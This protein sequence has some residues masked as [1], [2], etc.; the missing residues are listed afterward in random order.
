M[1][2]RQKGWVIA[3]VLVAVPAMLVMF[4]VAALAQIVT[5]QVTDT[6]YR[7]DGTPAGGTVLISWPA[8][9]TSAGQSIASGN[10]SATLTASG[11][12]TV[13]LIP[14]A[15]ANPVGTYY[16]VVYHLD[17]GSVNR[18]YWVVPAS[19]FPVH[20]S[21]LRN[22]VVPTSV[23]MQTVSKSYVDTA[24]AS[25]VA[26]HP[27]DSSNPYVLKAGDTMTG[28]LSLPG[29]PTTPSQATTKNYVDTNVTQ[30]ASGLAQKVSVLPQTDQ[31][32]AQPTGTQLAT[33]RMNGVEYASQYQNSRGNNGIAN[34]VASPDCAGGCEIKAEQTYGPTENYTASQWNNGT[35]VEDHR[36][37]QRHDLYLN[38]DSP[39][40]PGLEAGQVI[41][42]TGTRPTSS[43]FQATHTQTPGS[44]GLLI[45]HQGVAGGSNQFPENI[46]ATVPYFKMGYSALQLKGTYNAQGQH[47]LAPMSSSCFGVGDCLIGSQL[48]LGSG[49]FRDNAD[50]GTHPFDLQILEDSRVFTGVCA[51]GCAPGST[52][53]AITATANSQTQGEGRYLIDTNPAKVLNTGSLIGAGTTTGPNPSAAFSGTNFPISTFFQ[54]AQAAVSQSNDLAP[55]TVTLPIAT[56]GLPTGFASNTAAAPAA[57]G[58]ACVTDTAAADFNIEKFET[59]NYSI[60]D[61]THL[62]LTLTRAHTANATVAIGGLCGYGLEQTVDTASGIRQVFPV[63][64]SYS[65]TG[66][67]YAGG[68]S[69]IVGQIGTTSA[70]ASFSLPITSVTR[71]GNTVTLVTSGNFP[72]DVNGLTL[73]VSGVSD[74]SYNGSFVVTTTSPNRLTYTQTGSNSTSSGG[75]LTL[76]TGGYA[77]YPMAEVTSVMN[78]ATK[79]I[80]GQ[81]TLAPNTVAWAANDTVEQ[82]HYYQQ[83]VSADTELIGQTIPRPS[84][85][86]QAGLQYQGNNG[87]GLQG[88]AITNAAPVTN[89]YGNGGTH[90][91]PDVALVTKGAWRRSMAIDA[92]EQAVFA[93]HCNLH[94]CGKWNSSYNLF[95]IDSSVGV[96][97]IGYIPTTSSINFNL[98][99]TPYSFSPQGFTAGTINATTVNATTLNG[100]VAAS[101]LPV[102]KASGAAHAPGVVPDPGSVAGNTRYLREDGTWAAPPGNGSGSSLSALLPT[103]A[104]ADYSFK[105]GTGTTV[106]DASGNGNNATLGSG[107]NAPTWAPK[108]GLSFVSTS[109]VALPATLNTSKTFLI[110]LYVTPVGNV[111]LVNSGAQPVLISSSMGI[112]GYNFMH[113]ASGPDNSS[114]YSNAWSFRNYVS[115]GTRSTAYA[116]Y[117]GFHVLSITLGTIGSSVDHFY[118]DGV[119]V[120]SYQLQGASGGV[121]TT[122][123]LFLGTSLVSAFANSGF[124]GTLYRFVTYDAQLTSSQVS[125]ASLAIQSEIASRGVI[126]SPQKVSVGTPQLYAIGD[127]ITYGRYNNSATFGWPAHLALDNASAWTVNNW[128]VSGSSVEDIFAAEPNR[129]APRCGDGSTP[130]AAVLFLGTNSFF[131]IGP[132]M[133]PALVFAHLTAEVQLLKKAG[134]RVFVGTMLSRNGFDTQKDS[135]DALIL[136][137]YKLIGADGVVDF[138]ANPLVG[139]DGASSNSTYFNTDLT[140]PKDPGQE[141]LAA[142][143]SNALNY[144]YGYNETNPNN[145][146]SLPYAMNAGDGAISLSGLTASGTITL[147]DCTG[148]SGAIYR[149]NNPQSALAVSVA[150]LNA[151]QLIN[152]LAFGTAVPVPANGTLTLRDVPNPKNVAGC[153]WEM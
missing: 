83:K 115:S 5:T 123:N 118:L 146:T 61:G 102:F 100:S 129:L 13:Q 46:D 25:A 63:I 93:I 59:V 101:Q 108:G 65:A 79:L 91:I 35:H 153:H 57:S 58:V 29:D 140:H 85:R 98:R 67:Y 75:T 66:L 141:I 49:G 2:L 68:T 70:F 20:I 48:I 64:G 128:G 124:V 96:D 44:I 144:Y 127:S 112:T 4:A 89:Y 135:Y 81:M 26:G 56:T 142:E 8:F 71:S 145:V 138:A 97:A 77:L 45:R 82:P 106:T 80:D 86:Q 76:L 34:A 32:I 92:G 88:W 74:A 18:E 105:E 139:A 87:P 152:G 114:H 1:S 30:L 134:C 73:S 131:E 39:T 78:P 21:S 52:S 113:I 130:S 33:N 38:P 3:A 31:A 110:G 36:G 60:V 24:I 120:G 94:T 84:S 41:D 122:G 42:V 23:A 40:S 137:Q 99:G 27:L 53:V 151:S 28:A 133:T 14:N 143:A 147:P 37:G 136:S 125:D 47:V 6:I 43:I 15:G 103:P 104:T 121:Q 72:A 12:L 111:S 150:P 17:D 95:E 55:G 148:Q 50:E 90:T 22:T 11:V 62:Q 54:L 149:I 109:Q 126:T 132:A 107:I 117:S 19:Q 119:E 16:T 51:T 7:A 10:T 116:P 9:T 69:A